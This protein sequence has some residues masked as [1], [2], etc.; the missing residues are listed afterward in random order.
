M[1]NSSPE[2][3]TILGP[4]SK[5]KGDLSFDSAAKVLGRFEGTIKSKGK[6]FIADGSNCHASVSAKEVA[7]EGQIEGNVEAAERI[8]IKP[9]GKI[10]GDIVASR[11][12]MADG[13][14]IEGHVR[15]GLDGKN[16]LGKSAT[17][18]EPK[19]AAKQEG[20]P[21]RARSK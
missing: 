12:T 19:L 1:A 14:T 21:E 5:F 7:I 9:S 10:T 20:I 18:T 13:A 4:D 15:I 8:E 2:Y 16:A 6:I 3:G 17:A 11:M